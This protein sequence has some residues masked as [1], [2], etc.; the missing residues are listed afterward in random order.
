MCNNYNQ[1][2]MNTMHDDK[3]NRY[4]YILLDLNKSTSKRLVEQVKLERTMMCTD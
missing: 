2:G 4:I 1:P 3:Q